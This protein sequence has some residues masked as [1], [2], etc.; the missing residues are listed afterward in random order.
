MKRVRSP[1]SSQATETKKIIRNIK[2]SIDNGVD[3]KE[4]IKEAE[5]IKDT[6]QRQ[7]AIKAIVEYI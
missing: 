5:N 1:R 6:V 2:K 7:K 3:W 4:A